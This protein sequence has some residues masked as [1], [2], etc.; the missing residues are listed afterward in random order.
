MK[1]QYSKI[2]NSLK[3]ESMPALILIQEAIDENIEF[4]AK[5]SKSKKI[6]IATKSVRSIEVIKYIIKKLGKN[7]CSG[8][9]C[10]SLKE[11]LWLLDNDLDDILM[12]YPCVNTKEIESVLLLSKEKGARVTFMVDL[13]EHL[14]ILTSAAK[15]VNTEVSICIDI[16]MSLKLPFLNFGV[17]RSSVRTIDEL[18]KLIEEIK[19]RKELKLDA[20]MGYEAQVAGVPDRNSRKVIESWVVSLLKKFSIK[21]ITKLRESALKLASASYNISIFNGG[22]TGSINSTCA[23]EHISEITIGSGFYAP[24]LFDHYKSL[25]LSPA[26]VFGL[27]VTRNPEPHI[28]TCAGGGYIASGS[29]GLEKVPQPIDKELELISTEMMGEVQSPLRARNTNI[30][31]GDAILFRHAKAGELCEH[32]NKIWVYN[33]SGEKINEYKTYR[34]EG[35]KFL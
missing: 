3:E 9:M 21:K 34:G 8:L 16:D 23:E 11:A 26:L 4:F 30:N 5:E 31:L 24:K 13:V 22:G 14:N 1:H 19:N 12:G 28:Y 7:K 25:D 27:S 20:L 33:K 2:V 29:V 10:Y 6:R 32:F 17:Y 18:E 35:H 15:K